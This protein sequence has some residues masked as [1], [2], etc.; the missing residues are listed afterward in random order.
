MT[1]DANRGSEQVKHLYKKLP[2]QRAILVR[3]AGRK[4]KGGDP[5]R[6]ER[7][8]ALAALVRAY[9][10]TGVDDEAAV[11]LVREDLIRHGKDDPRFSGE[12]I[13][14]LKVPSRGT[15][16]AAYHRHGRKR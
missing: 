3:I 11:A 10:E 13:E 1:R 7:D 6:V 5:H 2:S 15:I 16:K 8:R 12:W 9:T 14:E 4:E